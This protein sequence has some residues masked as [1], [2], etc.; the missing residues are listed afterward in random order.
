MM[1]R[2]RKDHNHNHEELNSMM[3]RPKAQTRRGECKVWW[4]IFGVTMV[5]FVGHPLFKGIWLV[6]YSKIY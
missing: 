4:L 2:G 6:V 1:K 5:Y 3:E